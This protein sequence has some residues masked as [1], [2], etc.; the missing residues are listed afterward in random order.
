MKK[1]EINGKIGKWEITE[2]QQKAN[3]IA[4]QMESEVKA[5]E[6]GPN[7]D[8]CRPKRRKWKSQARNCEYKRASCLNFE[9]PNSKKFKENSSKNFGLHQRAQSHIAVETKLRLEDEDLKSVKK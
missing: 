1:W 6:N 3:G 9:S 2:S 8:K 5:R 7:A 4:V